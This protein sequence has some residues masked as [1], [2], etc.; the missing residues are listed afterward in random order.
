[1][2]WWNATRDGL[3]LQ[4]EDTGLLWGDGPADAMDDALSEIVTVFKESVGRN[5][6]KEEVRA[7]LEFSIGIDEEDAVGVR[8]TMKQQEID[9]LELEAE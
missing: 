6:T 5:P 1:M 9:I 4:V 8:K 7:G 3:S 2:G